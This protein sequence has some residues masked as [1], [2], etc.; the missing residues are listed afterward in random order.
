MHRVT[1]R[2]FGLGGGSGLLLRPAGTLSLGDSLAASG[3]DFALLSRGG[4][5]GGGWGRSGAA[6]KAG[7]LFLHGF[8][9]VLESGGLAELG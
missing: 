5:G 6:E 7:Q 9:L 4:S 2:L 8:D 1:R 3:G